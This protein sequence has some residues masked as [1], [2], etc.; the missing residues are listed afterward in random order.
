[1]LIL[2]YYRPNIKTFMEKIPQDFGTEK[3]E[4]IL[5]VESAIKESLPI[6]ELV[7]IFGKETYLI[8]GAVRDV[9]LN[10]NPS[11]L[12]LMSRM[13][14]DAIRKNLEDAGFIEMEWEEDGK[15]MEGKYSFKK[16]TNVFNLTIDEREVQVASI[17]EKEVSELIS[18]ADINLSCCAFDLNS[19]KIIDPDFMLEIMD[20]ELR[21]IDLELAKN[22]PM[23]I[24]NALKQISRLPDL[25]VSS[26]TMEIINQSMPMVIDFFIKNPH[27]RHKLRPLFGNINSGQVLSLFENFDI[28]D[29][30]DDIDMK[31]SKLNVSDVYFSKTVEELAPD[32]KDKLSVFVASQFGKRFDSKKLFNEK[33]NSVA[34]ELDDSGEIVSCCLMGG[35]RLYATSSVNSEKIVSLVSDLCKHN[36]NVWS[37]ISITSTHLINLCPKAGLHIVEDPALIERV[38]ISNY[39]G[40]KDKLIIKTKRGHSVFSK[41]ESNDTPQVLVM[42]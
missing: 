8:G 27:R 15:F 31:K 3:T 29:I 22:D 20:K 25:K 33:V 30:L 6:D 10:K 35:E 17:G 2:P 21:F 11:D 26:E 38:L 28:G 37:T 32:I 39:P 5:R 41:E 18:T 7:R 34:Y 4:E 9:I 16:G 19:L 42:S 1:V 14:V 13:P 40:Y 36:Y 23:K 24:V 12:D